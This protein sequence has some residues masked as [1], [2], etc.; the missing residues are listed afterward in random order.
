MS[1]KLILRVWLLLS[2]FWQLRPYR[3][4]SARASELFRKFEAG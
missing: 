2:I 3:A 1:F 4:G